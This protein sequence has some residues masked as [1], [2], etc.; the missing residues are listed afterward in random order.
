MLLIVEEEKKGLKYSRNKNEGTCPR[1]EREREKSVLDHSG[2]ELCLGREN[3]REKM[4]RIDETGKT[5][6]QKGLHY[7][8]RYWFRYRFF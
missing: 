2:L 6:P 1:D 7:S 8:T 3:E 5:L 4:R